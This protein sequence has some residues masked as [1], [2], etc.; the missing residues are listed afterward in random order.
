MKKI[1]CCCMALFSAAFTGIT[2]V[3]T[4]EVP[5]YIIAATETGSVDTM[6][7]EHTIFYAEYIEPEE[8]NELHSGHNVLEMEYSEL[9]TE[10]IEP[11]LYS[12]PYEDIELIAL[13]TAAEAEGESVEGKRLV[14]DTILNRIDSIHFPN[15]AYDVIYQQNQFSAMWNGRVDKCQIT[16][17]LIQLVLEELDNRYNYETIFFNANHYSIYGYPLFQVG[18]HYFSRY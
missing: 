13:V 8:T 7:S 16:D 17:E 6:T 15:N 14:I 4:S 1:F 12:I 10:T 5:E 9:E 18:N 2:T 11:I 3:G